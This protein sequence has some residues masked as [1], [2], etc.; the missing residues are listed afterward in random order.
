M[1]MMRAYLLDGRGQAADGRRRAAEPIV[2]DDLADADPAALDVDW[3]EEEAPA[4][5]EGAS[6]FVPASADPYA[7]YMASLRDAPRYD[8]DEEHE[9]AVE[10]GKTHDPEIARKLV[11][12]NLKLVVK[13]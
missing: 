6:A 8:R 12:A 3:T 4:V 9:L 2:L 13:L 5:V 1:L 10:Y 11:T 7:A